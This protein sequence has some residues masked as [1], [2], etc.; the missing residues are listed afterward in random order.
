MT[1]GAGI[2]VS[3]G[4]LNVLGKTILSDVRDN[5]TVTPAAVGMS[6]NGAFIGVRSDRTGS[7]T[8]FPVGKLL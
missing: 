2:S 4:N 5:I 6:S 1:I 3:V 7:R 8:V